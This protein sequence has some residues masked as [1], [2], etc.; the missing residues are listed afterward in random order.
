MAKT[1]EKTMNEV[2]EKEVNF[3][4][5]E[6]KIAKPSLNADKTMVVSGNFTELGANIKALVEKY[7]NTKLTMDNISYV[8]TLKGHFTSLRTG[9]ERERKEWKKVYITPASKLIDSMCDELQKIV[10]EGE[11]ALSVQLEEFDNK[12]KEELTVILKEYVA[13]SV[14]KHNLR[15][16]YAT[17]IQLLDK[18]YNKTQEEEDSADDIERQASELEK[19]QKEYDSGVELIKAECEDAGFLPDTYIRE[20]NYKSAMEI[21]LEVKADKKKAKEMQDKIDSGEK[22]VVGKSVD[23]ELKNAL[24]ASNGFED[25]EDKYR[26]RILRVR[27]LASQ[28]KLMG[29][30]FKEN[31]IQFEFI[32]K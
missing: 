14:A 1:K 9:I 3:G 13:E 24:D 19:K 27:Y 29:R 15:D 25:E 22:V 4:E 2:T 32:E 26:E 21:I 17:Q 12:R 5:L 7:K 8:K 31:N 30:F 11:S 16:E 28:A 18:Y 10:E 20:L 23:D 6:L